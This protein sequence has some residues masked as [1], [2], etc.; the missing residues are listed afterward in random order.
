MVMIR[1]MFYL[2][3]LMSLERRGCLVSPKV[4]VVVREEL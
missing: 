2:S 3:L 4:G 1:L